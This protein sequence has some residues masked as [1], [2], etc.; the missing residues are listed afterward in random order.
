M[1]CI[2]EH[3]CV[4]D[5]M[6]LIYHENDGVVKHRANTYMQKQRKIDREGERR[7][8]F[9]W[10]VNM[11]FLSISETVSK[12]K[13]TCLLTPHKDISSILEEYVFSI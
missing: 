10:T 1:G 12:F 13:L 7:R 4:E 2:V 5:H 8:A 9:M 3:S 6:F 11:W